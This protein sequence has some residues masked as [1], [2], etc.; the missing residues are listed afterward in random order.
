MPFN[1]MYEKRASNQKSKF[2]FFTR[3]FGISAA[4]RSIVRENAVN[5]CDACYISKSI[6]D[7]K[8]RQGKLSIKKGMIN[9]YLLYKMGSVKWFS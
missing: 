7:S 2:E 9:Y 1:P 5:F 6:R 8:Y 4:E 3:Y